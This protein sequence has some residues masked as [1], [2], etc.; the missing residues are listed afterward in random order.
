MENTNDFLPSGYEKPALSSNYSRFEEGDNKFRVLSPAIIGYEYW[1]N[2]NKPIR[3]K[4]VF[5]ETPNIKVDKNGKSRINHFWAFIIWD[6]KEKDP[7]V[8]IMQITQNSI[9]EDMINI[10]KDW[11]NPIEYDLNIVRTGKDFNNTKYTVMPL[12]STDITEEMATAKAEMKIDLTKLYTGED[13]FLNNVA[14]IPVEVVPVVQGDASAPEA[15][16]DETPLKD[17]I[18]TSQIPF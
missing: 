3:S 14:E 18:D 2:E 11:G 13:P 12:K 7:G 15:P 5:T 9:Q 6:Y 4:E 16:L 10:Y 8:K 1:S 17:E